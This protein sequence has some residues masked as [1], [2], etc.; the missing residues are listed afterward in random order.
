M[1]LKKSEGIVKKHGS[2]FIKPIDN[3]LQSLVITACYDGHKV[4]LPFH[5][6]FGN[7]NNKPI[8]LAIGIKPAYEEAVSESLSSVSRFRYIKQHLIVLREKLFDNG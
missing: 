3:L 5:F 1:L 7:T 6:A 4:F 8:T 2:Y